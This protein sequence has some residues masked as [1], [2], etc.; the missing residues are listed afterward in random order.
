MT[1]LTLTDLDGCERK[2]DVGLTLIRGLLGNQ[3]PAGG[4]GDS[5]PVGGEEVRC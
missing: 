4:A 3:A 1:H 5:F 2:L